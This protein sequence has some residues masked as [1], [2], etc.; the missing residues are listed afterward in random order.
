MRYLA[1]L[2]LSG[3]SFISVAWVSNR[4]ENLSNP[5]AYEQASYVCQR[6]AGLYAM[7]MFELERYGEME[8]YHDCMLANGYLMVDHDKYL[9]CMSSGFSQDTCI[10][11][12]SIHTMVAPCPTLVDCN[13]YIWV[14]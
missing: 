1:L 4:P 14:Q 12:C 2:C 7:D 11:T 6:D 13:P 8:S 3:C 10:R 9:W 5:L